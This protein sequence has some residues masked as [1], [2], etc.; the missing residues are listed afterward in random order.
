MFSGIYRIFNYI[1]RFFFW[2]VE[3][4]KKRDFLVG[5]AFILFILILFYS[6]IAALGKLASMLADFAIVYCICFF[7]YSL[8]KVFIRY[9]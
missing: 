2:T 5:D 1:S 4:A 6:E 8:Y 7:F 9:R 3:A